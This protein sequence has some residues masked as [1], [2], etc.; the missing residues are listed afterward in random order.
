MKNP[1]LS[2]KSVDELWVLHEQVAHILSLKILE[3][4]VQLEKKLSKLSLG[5]AGLSRKRARRPYPAVLPKFRNPLQPAETWAGRGKQPRW[6]R[7][8]LKRG[9]QLDD[10]RIRA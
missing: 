3:E 5:T 4:K 8:Q 7:A 2:N 10:F 6:L 9:R 1:D